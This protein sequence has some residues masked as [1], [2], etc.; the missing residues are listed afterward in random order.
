MLPDSAI[1]G[2]SIEKGSA[3]LFQICGNNKT[4]RKG[5]DYPR[6]IW[7]PRMSKKS[8]ID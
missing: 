3:F 1:N 6:K 4:L 5:G 2:V 8:G 7:L